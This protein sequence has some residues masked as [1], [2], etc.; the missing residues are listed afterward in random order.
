MAVV[1]YKK[2]E[3]QPDPRIWI[4][5]PSFNESRRLSGTLKS[6]RGFPNI[7]VVDDGS[8]DNTAQVATEGSAQ[9]VRNENN[10]GQ[11]AALARGIAEALRLG[12]EVIVS[13]DG[14]GQHDAG[15][16]DALIAP[17][18]AGR[19]DVVLGSRFKGKA[20]NMPPL[21]RFMIWTGVWI[22]RVLT[23]LKLSDTHNG[24]R[25]FNRSAAS[26]LT[27]DSP[28]RGHASQ[29]LFEIAFLKLRY[30]EIPVTVRYLGDGR[31]V[32]T[33]REF[34]EVFLET[35]QLWKRYRDRK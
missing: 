25:A 14:D 24:L 15:D 3:A 28:R 26:R 20:L 2:P 9:V 18:L 11:G 34:L 29:I 22:T 7:L 10:Q 4:V 30:Q 32:A 33:T 21:H 6:L 31:H 23:G 16:L 13:F 5:I 19:V 27:L 12:A 1:Q 8:T 35:L 17:V